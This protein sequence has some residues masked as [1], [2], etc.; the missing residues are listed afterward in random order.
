MWN[1]WVAR[2][3]APETPFEDFELARWTWTK[4]NELFPEAIAIVLMPNHLHLLLSE[5]ENSQSQ[6]PHRLGGL[7][8]SVTKRLKQQALWQP[9]PPHSVI[10]D[11]NHLKR[12][13]RYLALNPCRK[14]L[15]A[16][17][18]SWH[19]S[20]YREILG[21]SSENPDRAAKIIRTLGESDN[22]FQV[23]F[24]AYVSGDPSVCVAGTPS[25]V[26]AQPTELSRHSLGEILE[27]SAAAMRVRSCEIQA[28]FRLRHLFI[29]LAYN[30]GWNRPSLLAQ[31][32]GQSI[33]S[34]HWV[35]T[36][37]TPTGL[38]AAELCLGDRRLIHHPGQ[39]ESHPLKLNLKPMPKIQNQGVKV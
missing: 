37:T 11:R 32:C 1:H 28:N 23:R 27:A 3:F 22:N 18:T 14:R 10:P 30:Y 24:H 34:I 38:E 9:I 20:T 17:P 19:W 6:V 12:Q 13:I 16:D 25:P 15:C 8:G 5:K 21:A 2:T 31:I 36:K 35:L 4:I 33:S 29:H 7:L 26:R 39:P